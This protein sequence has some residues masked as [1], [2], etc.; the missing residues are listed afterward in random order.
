MKNIEVH[1]SK[2]AAH[3]LNERLFNDGKKRQ[4]MLDMINGKMNVGVLIENKEY[5]S[6]YYLAFPGIGY[7][8]A[9]VEDGGKYTAATF[10]SVLRAPIKGPEVSVKYSYDHEPDSKFL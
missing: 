5:N 1:I 4:E 10:K 7:V 8:F 2:H 3:R 9:L 6:S